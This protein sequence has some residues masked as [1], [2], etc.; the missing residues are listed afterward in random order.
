MWPA[1]GGVGW[2]GGKEIV[3]TMHTSRHLFHRELL[4]S[5]ESQS[6]GTNTNTLE[7]EG[8]PLRSDRQQRYSFSARCL[9]THQRQDVTHS[10]NPLSS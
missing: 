10:K 1:R 8:R 5:C 2:V 3:L 7:S 4:V 6:T 9:I